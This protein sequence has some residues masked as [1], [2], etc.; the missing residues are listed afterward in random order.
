MLII[1]GRVTV[2]PAARDAYVAGCVPVVEAARHAPGCLEF[3]ITAD[4]VD[5]AA[6]LVYERWEDEGPLLAF[7]GA[8]PS[9]EQEAAIRSMDVRRYEISAVSEP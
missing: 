7:R 9:P 6:V 8:G 1:A 2:D 5:P 4:T 3:S